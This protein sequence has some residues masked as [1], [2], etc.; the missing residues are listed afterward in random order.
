MEQ[1]VPTGKTYCVKTI[2]QLSEVA[3]EAN[4]D[5]LL[6]DLKICLL[7]VIRV[8]AIHHV[9]TGNQGKFNPLLTFDWIDDG[10]NELKAIKFI[11]DD[12]VEQFRIDKDSFGKEAS[13]G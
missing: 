4:I 6:A 11:D 7:S 5:L 1:H 12:G 13:N 9:I 2:T 8:N 3:T 10:L